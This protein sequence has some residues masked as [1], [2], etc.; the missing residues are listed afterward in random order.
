MHRG[1][2]LL[3]Q[4]RAVVEHAAHLGG[5]AAERA[6]ALAQAGDQLTGVATGGIGCRLG[7]RWI[8]PRRRGA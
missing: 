2:L 3:G 6:G 7:G 5:V 4:A 1:R 8:R